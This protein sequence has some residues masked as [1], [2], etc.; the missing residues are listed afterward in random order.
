MGN[1]IFKGNLV[2]ALQL[3]AKKI[4]FLCRKRPTMINSN[5]LQSR[6]IEKAAPSGTAS[7]INS[8]VINYRI[9]LLTLFLMQRATDSQFSHKRIAIR[10]F[11]SQHRSIDVINQKIISAG[12][13]NR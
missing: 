2:F 12:I 3:K 5:C 8:Q 1:W 7:Q 10:R 11:K 9:F 4:P 13:R 6:I